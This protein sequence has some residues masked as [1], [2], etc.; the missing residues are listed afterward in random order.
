M[1]W[2]EMVLDRQT[3]R[4]R[5]E[6]E[7]R[8]LRELEEEGRPHCEKCER[9]ITDDEALYIG[10]SYYCRECVEEMFVKL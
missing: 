4:W 1:A 3:E 5:E 7:A 2:D 9:L 8:R 10:W 6:G